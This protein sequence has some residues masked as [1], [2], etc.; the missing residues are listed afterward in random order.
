MQCGHP[1]IP[2]ELYV[3]TRIP[4][5]SEHHR[6]TERAIPSL[7]VCSNSLQPGRCYKAVSLRYRFAI[8]ACSGPVALQVHNPPAHPH[9]STGTGPCHTNGTRRPGHTYG[10]LPGRERPSCTSIFPPAKEPNLANNLLQS[11]PNSKPPL[12]T[13]TPFST[14]ASHPQKVRFTTVTS[15]VADC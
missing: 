8:L 9:L 4:D 3:P 2:R 15:L 14:R 11:T 13:S 7:L 6:H 10:P 12:A 1:E 5:P